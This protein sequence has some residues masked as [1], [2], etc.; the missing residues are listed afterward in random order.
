MAS[1]TAKTPAET[2]RIVTEIEESM[3]KLEET[4][5]KDLDEDH[6]KSVLIGILDPITRQHTCLKHGPEVKF[7]TLKR[8]V[9]EFTSNATDEQTSMQLG[10]LESGMASESGFETDNQ[11]GENI[12]E[13][14]EQLGAMGKGSTQ[15]YSCGGYGHMSRE[16]PSAK[17]K[18]KSQKGFGGFGKGGGKGKS[19]GGKSFYGGPKGGPYS[20]NK[21]EGKSKGKDGMKGSGKGGPQQGCWTCG[22]AHYQ[23]NC[24]SAGKG[25]SMRHFEESQYGDW[26]AADSVRSRC[27]LSMHVE[28]AL[29]EKEEWKE[30]EKTKNQKDKKKNQKDKKAKEEETFVSVNKWNT[31]KTDDEEE[32]GKC[33][34][35]KIQKTIRFVDLPGEDSNKLMTFKTIF[36]EGL[37]VLGKGEWEMIELAVDS[38]ATETVVGDDMLTS[39]ETKESWGSKK[40][41]EYEVA[42]GDTI[43]NLGEKKFNGVTESGI[44]RNLTAQVCEVN[45]AL[46]SV[47]KI[48]SAGNRVTFDEDGSFIED[49]NTG[50]RMWLREEGGMFMLKMW[51][52]GSVF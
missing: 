22:G 8:L 12:Q 5:D 32:T 31:L 1:R 18:G 2:K 41:V 13:W 39:I 30:V 42:N 21:G 25:G 52:K 15:C 20:G 6:A 9:L 27:C 33:K 46:L 49:K 29:K 24:P 35:N 26:Q 14:N 28:K 4:M 44:T 51:V 10:R 47:K 43:P 17:G 36:P 38:G 3:K 45:K 37:N 19:D 16:C 40:G 23:S 34:K 11:Q 50:E 48:I 7:E